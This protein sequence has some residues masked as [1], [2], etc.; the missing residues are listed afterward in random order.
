[1]DGRAGRVW[2]VPRAYDSP[3]ARVF[4]YILDEVFSSIYTEHRGSP[5]WRRQGGLLGKGRRLGGLMERK[6]R[7]DGLMV[8]WCRAADEQCGCCRYLFLRGIL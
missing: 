6:C 1:M 7:P 8:R 2:A 4:Q 5:P 3:V